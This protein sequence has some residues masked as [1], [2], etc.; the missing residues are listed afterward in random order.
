MVVEKNTL[1]TEAH[2]TEDRAHRILLRKEWSSKGKKA[3]VL[4]TNASTAGMV[5]MD[6]TTQF[7]VNNLYRLD[8]GAVDIVNIFSRIT[9]KVK[10]K[11]GTD[12]LTSEENFEQIKKSA[13]LAD[14]IIIAWG[15]LGDNNK[16]VKAVQNKVLEIL[17]PFADK[18]YIIADA[19]GKRQGYHPLAAP[20][21]EAWVLKQWSIPKA[22]PENKTDSK[23]PKETK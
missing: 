3:M 10:T 2:Y 20:V 13:E 12:S 19:Q 5:S 18:L 17:R 23:P 7:V 22:E 9:T 1:K 8:Y 21:R 14:S 11:D 16:K 6:Y 15:A 4:M